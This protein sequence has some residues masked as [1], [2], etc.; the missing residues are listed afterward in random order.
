MLTATGVVI[1]CDVM[2]EE[3]VIIPPVGAGKELSVGKNTYTAISTGFEPGEIGDGEPYYHLYMIWRE[4]GD[5]I[6]SSID[7]GFDINLDPDNAQLTVEAVPGRSFSQVNGRQGIRVFINIDL[8]TKETRT[9]ID[10][11]PALVDDDRDH[12]YLNAVVDYFRMQEI[13]KY[14]AAGF[15]EE[16]GTLACALAEIDES[17]AVRVFYNDQDYLVEGG[18]G[19]ILNLRILNPENLSSQEVRYVLWNAVKTIGEVALMQLPGQAG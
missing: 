8:A 5:E 4:I 10:E 13:S 3:E 6:P 16:K 12:D 9:K 17:S 11:G 14:L 18:E 7:D 1:Y 15:V 19:G 2:Q